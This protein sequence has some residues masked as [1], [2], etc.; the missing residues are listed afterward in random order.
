MGIV[1]T[2]PPNPSTAGTGRRPGLAFAVTIVAMGLI[3]FGVTGTNLA[4]PEIDADFAVSRAVLS[5]ALSG[6][7]ITLAALQLLGGQLSDRFD[8]RRMFV[9]GLV[10]FGVASMIAAVAPNAGLLIAG[11]CLQGAGGALVIPASLV[12]ATSQYPTERHP[13]VIAIWTA[14]FPIG[15]ALAPVLTA[16]ALQL[17]SWRWMFGS[18]AIAS[19]LVIFAARQIGLAPTPPKSGGSDSGLP[20]VLGV[21]LGTAGVGLL[22]LAIVQGPG[23][24]WTGGRVLGA[25]GASIVLLGAFVARSLHHP[26]PMMDLRLFRIRTFT[27]AGVSNVFISMAGMSTWLVWPLVMSNEWGYSPIEVGLAI[28][29]TPIIAGTVSMLIVRWTR[30]RGFRAVLATGSLILAAGNLWFVLALDATPSYLGAMLP[31][32]LLYGLGMGLTFAPVNAAALVDIDPNRYG[33]ANAGF[34]TGRFLAGALGIAA[35]IAALGDGTGDPFAGY[36]RAFTLLTA[37]SIA[38]AVLVTVAWPRRA[39]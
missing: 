26:R 22:T 2:A 16:L 12:V 9:A 33:Q 5:W 6:Y 7:S 21:V 31:G 10:V 27:I 39:A 28:T 18:I 13:F 24:G 4:F 14:A 20:D 1:S 11:R 8:A 3:P 38:A 36:D 37:V 25:L 19:G 35:T 30:D 17:G 32:L 15:S 29:P 23:W 34:S